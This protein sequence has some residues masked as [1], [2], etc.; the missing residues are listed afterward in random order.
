MPAS[1]WSRSSSRICTPQKSSRS[2]RG[3]QDRPGGK[4][5]RDRHTL[6]LSAGELVGSD[7]AFAETDVREDPIDIGTVPAVGSGR[8]RL[9]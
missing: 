9:P 2:A 6:L 4:R 5:T 8:F 1:A 3:E 7:Q